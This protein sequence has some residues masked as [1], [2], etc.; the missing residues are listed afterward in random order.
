[1]RIFNI[2]SS[3]SNSRNG[4]GGFTLIEVI[5]ASAIILILAA[6][7]TSVFLMATTTWRYGSAQVALQMKLNTAME[8]IINGQRAVAENRTYGLREAEQIVVIDTGTV[9]FTNGIDGTTRYFYLDGNEVKYG[10]DINGG[11][12]SVSIYDPSRLEDASNAE[13]HR[14]SLEFVQL[15]NGAVRIQLFAETRVRDRW[16]NAALVSSAAPRN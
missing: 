13:N 7:L 3:N 12:N 14:T 2:V 11:Q 10:P 1:M 15:D 16:L 6:G 9:E 4:T 8:R 5:T